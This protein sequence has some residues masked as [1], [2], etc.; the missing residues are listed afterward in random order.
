M[1]FTENIKEAIRSSK[2]NRLRT[3][4]TSM[5]I[6]IGIISLVG[7]LT[8]VDGIKNTVQESFAGLGSNSFDIRNRQIN[9]SIING[10]I[11][12]KY[13]DI[14][15]HQAKLYKEKMNKSILVT[16]KTNID[17]DAVVKYES[18][19][20]N[21]NSRILAI[22]ENFMQVKGFTLHLGRGFN[23]QEIN[24]GTPVCILG[25][26]IIDQL[27]KNKINPIGNHVY[28][29]GKPFKIIGTLT[30]KGS[31]S[32]GHNNKNIFI[33]LESGRK[34]NTQ[35]RLSYD[36]TSTVQNIKDIKKNLGEAEI[37]MRAI[38]KNQPKDPSSFTV[39]MSDSMAKKL[40]GLTMTLKIAGIF[41]SLITLL[42]ASLALM[43]IMMVSV[44][45]R[46]REIGIRKS[47]GATPK[48]IRYQFLTES[49]IICIL[50]CL[51]GITIAIPVGNLIANM[52]SE[53]ESKFIMP[54]VWINLA[55]FISIVV[56]I[57]SGIIP[58]N[59]ASRLDP[60]ESL[61]YE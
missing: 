50:G 13:P 38:R 14:S 12:K 26:E 6:A 46:T 24:N 31:L 17:F 44:T 28:I 61:R 25:N 2:A 47:L 3:I 51:A 57:L 30:K 53:G 15:F 11:E 42:G 43:N 48:T 10:N 8:A 58:A 21:P 60:I 4:L 20:T 49:I 34:L 1:N 37:I 22:D 7:I 35:K 9:R 45:E 27:F 56:G 5:I 59:K 32:G 40:D 36:I 23:N 16:I 39:E 41:I 18:E 54:W 55:I 29:Y 33:P 52:V 19:K